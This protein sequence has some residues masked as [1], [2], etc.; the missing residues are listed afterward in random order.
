MTP[1]TLTLP[2][3]VQAAFRV[4]GHHFVSE[5]IRRGSVVTMEGDVIVI[6]VRHESFEERLSSSINLPI[7]EREVARIL[8]KSYPVRIELAK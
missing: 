6:T 4:R 2:E 3:R 8:H 7:I 5:V 1:S